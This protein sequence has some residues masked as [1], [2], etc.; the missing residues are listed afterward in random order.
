MMKKKHTLSRQLFFLLPF[1]FIM[2]DSP[3]QQLGANPER[4]GY[5]SGDPVGHSPRLKWRVKTGDRVFSSPIGYKDRIFVGSSDSL[6]YALAKHDGQI[7]WTFKAGGQIRSSVALQ[8]DIIYFSATDGRFYAIDA[9]Q[10]QLKWTFLTA[11]ERFHD[12][13]DY[14]LSSPAVHQKTVYFGSGDSCIYA[15]DRLTG[16]LEWKFKTGAIVH[17]SPVVAD[18]AVLV[19]SFDGFFYCLEPDGR[20]RW[21]FKTIGERYFPR[22]EIQFHATA[23]AHTVYFCSR[24]F[25]VYALNTRDGAG[26]WVYHQ[27]GSWT[28]VP[29]LA[30]GKLLVTM[31]DA[32]LLLALDPESGKILFEA[33][34]PLNVFSGPSVQG[35]FAYT[36]SMDG[37]MYR[38]NLS[39]GTSDII[40]QTE[41]SR[42][43]R[44]DFFE[45]TGKLRASLEEK[46]K[47]NFLQMY[48]DFLKMGSILSTVW[49]DSG[50][51]FF[52]SADGYVYALE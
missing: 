44:P 4:S 32:H 23:T 37:R 11:G 5:F 21:K 28:S 52:G 22:G 20:L 17:A 7:L 49:I 40:F 34:L 45:T 13:W 14:H 2:N 39:S 29:A 46:Y 1:L 51:L 24:D 33:P 12:T 41:G 48:A 10:G 25:N 30:D 47:D 15:L 18:G 6:L 19:G 9:V 26:Y 35:N 36:G 50:M 31:S 43:H 38:I 42:K 8:E 3:A 16:K 27:Q